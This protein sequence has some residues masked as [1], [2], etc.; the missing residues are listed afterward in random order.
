[1]YGTTQDGGSEGAGTIFRLTPRQ[2]VVISQP[3]PASEVVNAGI[4]LTI[5][6]GIFAAVPLRAQ[7]V[8]NDTNLAGQT[9]TSL[10]LHGV[11]P[12]MSGNYSLRVTNSL[13]WAWTSNAVLTV[14]TSLIT[15]R[16]VT[17]VTATDVVLNGS[18]TP[19]TSE[20]LV[21]FE[22]GTDTNYGNIDGVTDLPA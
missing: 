2:P 13:G 12:S 4:D 15:N 21:W 6:A 11:T 1:L 18:V 10:T 17:G 5:D 7:W 20:T 8:F 16:A 19:G 14:L 9:N 22:W 3:R